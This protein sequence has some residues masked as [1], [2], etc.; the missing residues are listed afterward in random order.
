MDTD[1]ELV[2]RLRA[3]DEAAFA[4]L[5]ERYHPSL[6]RLAETMVP[7]RAVAEEVVQETWLGVVRG[8]S[9]F[10]GRSS[11]RT[12][13]F[14]ILVNRARTTGVRENRRASARAEWVPAVDPVRFGKDG[15]WVDPPTPWPDE[16]DDR[17]AAEMLAE[18]VR[19][20]LGELP[21][22]QRQVVTLRDLEGVS[23]ADVCQL[24]GIS[25]ANQRVLLHRGR[26]RIRGMLETEL[27][28]G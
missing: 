7:S 8:I 6:L 25:D 11:L 23:S 15:A 18:R 5:V 13:L 28:K 12:W 19:A 10:E 21:A 26:S 16:V 24:L 22:L 3:R 14:H 2:A 17:L 4:A 9:R 1:A 20:R 27:G